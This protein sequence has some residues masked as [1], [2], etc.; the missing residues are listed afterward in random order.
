MQRQQI[1]SPH[2]A[3]LPMGSRAR[4]VLVLVWS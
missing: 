3:V 2:H 1:V 4:N